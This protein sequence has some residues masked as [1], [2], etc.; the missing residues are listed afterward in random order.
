[1]PLE[2]A[3][4]IDGL[5][6]TNPA[7]G[8]GSGQGDDHLRLLKSVLKATF[9]SVAGAVTLS[10]TQIN[11]LDTRATALEAADVALDARLDTIEA[12]YIKKDGT[13]AFTGAQSLGG[14]KITSL[15]TPTA[16][17]D[18]ATKA[19]ADLKVTDVL[20]TRGDI[21]RGGVGGAEERLG[22]GTSGQVLSSD[23]TDV[24]WATPSS[25]PAYVELRDERAASTHGG[26]AT[27]GSWQT[28]TINTETADAG[29]H[30]SIA[31]NQITL[32]AGTYEC[33]IDAVAFAT[34]GHQARLQNITDGTTIALGTVTF[35]ETSSAGSQCASR[36]TAKF[37]LASS[38]TLEVQ[39]R[40]TSTRTTDGYGNAIAWG[41]NVYLIARF[42]KVA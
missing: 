10:H 30:A 1:M 32:A 13:V 18:A 24:V 23:G 33:E 28:R 31:S 29:G 25:S 36:I 20:T 5:V 17:T 4:Y 2:A 3:T 21:I 19:Y 6:S 35:N 11:A 16:T 38:K 9:P 39:S 40:V 26:T 27:S 22:L 15:G 14:F 37:T 34:A 7:A 42:W 41:T 12:A 8:D